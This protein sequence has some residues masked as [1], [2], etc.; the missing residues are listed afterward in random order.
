MKCNK[1]A[2][3]RTTLLK[4]VV[5]YDIAGILTPSLSEDGEIVPG[6]IVPVLT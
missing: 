1:T 4:N 3:K 6:G 5:E 2:Y